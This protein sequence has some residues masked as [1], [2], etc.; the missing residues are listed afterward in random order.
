M[1]IV[2]EATTI[3]NRTAKRTKALTKICK[4]IAFKRILTGSPV[5]KSPLDLFSQCNF[6][7]PELLGYTSFY[8]FRARYC[9]MKTIALAASGK[10]VALPLNFTNLDEL[11]KN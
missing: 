7:N 1:V 2:D 10:Q 9:V 3:K 4:P 6:L 11:E 8:A 5:T